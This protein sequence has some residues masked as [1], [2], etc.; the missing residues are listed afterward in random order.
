MCMKLEKERLFSLVQSEDIDSLTDDQLVQLF[1]NE[2]V[3]R[4]HAPNGRWE[5]DPRTGD[6][7]VYNAARAK[8]PH[9]NKTPTG[10]VSSENV[11]NRDNAKSCV[12]CEG[13]TTG[14]VDV[15]P[16]SSGFTFINKNMFPA[17][18]PNESFLSLIEDKVSNEEMK[19]IG[20]F[21]FLQWTSSEHDKDW[22]NLPIEDCAVVMKRLS[23]LEERL[24]RFNVGEDGN[25][26]LHPVVIKNYGREVGGSLSHGHQQILL[27]NLMPRFFIDDLRFANSRGEVFSAFLQRENPEELLVKD[28]GVAVLVVPFFMKRPYEMMLLIKDTN[29]NYIHELD[30]KELRAVAE[31]WHDAMGAIIEVMKGL[32]KEPAFNVITHNAPGAGLYFEFLPHTQ[33]MGGLEKLGFYICEAEPSPVASTLRNILLSRGEKK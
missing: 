3:V 17:L 2:E 1:L 14:V 32:G 29:K 21:H 12:I 28:Y 10:N 31:G 16:L 9:D 7:I 27:T 22:Y 15:V 20:G 26:R 24:L 5:K 23:V 4:N 30:E 6:R 33:A 11:D 18:F 8:R 19:R 25:T 13:N